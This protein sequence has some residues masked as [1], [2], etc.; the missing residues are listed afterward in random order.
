MYEED[1]FVY[2][3]GSLGTSGNI[4][5]RVTVEQMDSLN[6]TAMEVWLKHGS[7][8]KWGPFSRK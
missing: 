2:W 6:F 7:G 1:G 8:G 3:L 5:A 4:L